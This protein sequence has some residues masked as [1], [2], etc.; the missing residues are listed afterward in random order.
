M[1]ASIQRYTLRYRSLQLQS[2]ET[3]NKKGMLIEA[4]CVSRHNEANV[5]K[6]MCVLEKNVSNLIVVFFAKYKS[7]YQLF[8]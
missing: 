5:I 4:I 2:D 3:L 7:H 6:C 8:F 1:H